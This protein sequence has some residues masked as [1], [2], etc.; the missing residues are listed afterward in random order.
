MIDRHAFL[1]LKRSVI[2]IQRAARDWISRKHVSGNVLPQDLSTPTFI[3]AAIVIQKCIRG[4]IARSSLVNTEQF[5][6]VLMECEDNIHHIN[7]AVAIRCASKEY[8]LSSSLHSHH[9]AA[10]KIQSYYRGWLMRK[11]FVDQKQAAIKIQ[12]IFRSA[13]CLRDFHFYKQETLSVITIQAYIRKW[14][15]KRDVY[16]HKSQIILIQVIFFEMLKT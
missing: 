6:E 14:I 1:K 4:W 5:H 10:T 13:R 15:A 12:S 16:R 7:A 11:N 8:K 2:I 9:F 3:D